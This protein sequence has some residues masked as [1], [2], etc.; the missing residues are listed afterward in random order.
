MII[1]A[2]HQSLHVLWVI[3]IRALP[4]IFVVTLLK[5]YGLFRYLE[6]LAGKIVCR[7]AFSLETG[8]AFVANTGSAYAGGGILV[9][10]YRRGEISRADL[11]LSVVFAGFPG[12]VRV[13]VTSVGPVAFSLLT[14][15][16]AFFYVTLR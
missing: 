15:P 1:E 7:T 2:T 12:Y 5:E 11:V 8:Q 13:L 6:P 10:R 9:G 16:V 14:F 3:C 4:V